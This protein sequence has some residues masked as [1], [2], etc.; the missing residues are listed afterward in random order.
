M[1]ETK[2]S[3]VYCVP[4]NEEDWE[5]LGLLE[6]KNTNGY[7]Y[8][9][10]SASV[11]MYD[12]KA[13]LYEKSSNK[14]EVAVQQ[15]LDLLNDKI[16]DWRLEDIGFEKKGYKLYSNRVIDCLDD[17]VH[18]NINGVYTCL[19]IKTFTELKQIIKFLK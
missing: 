14:K 6:S 9:D 4:E 12:G 11:S 1:K 17:D 10:L 16:V 3:E 15:F 8:H 18:M 5:L 2:L 13:C 7:N 19:N